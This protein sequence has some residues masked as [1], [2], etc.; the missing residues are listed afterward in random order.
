MRHIPNMFIVLW[1]YVHDCPVFFGDRIEQDSYFA[2]LVLRFAREPIF[3]TWQWRLLVSFVEGIKD[4]Q[5]VGTAS[6]SIGLSPLR[7]LMHCSQDLR[8]NITIIRYKPEPY[9]S[10]HPANIQSSN[11]KLHQHIWKTTKIEIF[12]FM[13]VKNS[14]VRQSPPPHLL[15]FLPSWTCL[16]LSPKWSRRWPP[17]PRVMMKRIRGTSSNSTR[18]PVSSCFN[19]KRCSDAKPLVSGPRLLEVIFTGF[20]AFP[21]NDLF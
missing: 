3:A 10:L 14:I 4:Q 6:V 7:Q 19:P 9:K 8:E 15:Q 21:F 12:K 20:G 16:H 1:Y 5:Y 13:Q 17:L 18:S 2:T 11:S